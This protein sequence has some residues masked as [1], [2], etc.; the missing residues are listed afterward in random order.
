[1]QRAA[2][3][4]PGARTSSYFSTGNPMYLSRDRHTAFAVVYHPGGELRRPQRRGADARGR[5]RGL[6]AGITVEVT[7]RDALDEASKDGAG[8]G[9]SVLFEALIGGLGA[10]IVLLFVFGTLPAVLMP[11]AVAIAAILNT[12]T[13]VWA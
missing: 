5:E 9:S 2:A 13:L 7:G 6:P 12:F 11:L 3:S 4:V 1:M 10:L 8:G